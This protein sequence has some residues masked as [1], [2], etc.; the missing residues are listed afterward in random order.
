MKTK[1][2]PQIKSFKVFKECV[3]KDEI[4][5]GFGETVKTFYLYYGFSH[6]IQIKNVTSIKEAYKVY[7]KN[8]YYYDQF[9]AP[10][11][12]LKV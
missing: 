5:Y 6:A 10:N 4:E 12:F 3:R 8:Y 9:I 2:K 1:T 7:K 11:S